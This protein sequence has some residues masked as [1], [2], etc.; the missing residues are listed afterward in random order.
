M[1]KEFDREMEEGL[2]EETI[3]SR[4]GEPL[5]N[6]LELRERTEDKISNCSCSEMR[7]GPEGRGGRGADGGPVGGGLQGAGGI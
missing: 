2:R 5:E 1:E 3:E 7:D 4:L 6:L